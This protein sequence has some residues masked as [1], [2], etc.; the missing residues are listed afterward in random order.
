MF[1][2]YFGP[3]GVKRKIEGK[4]AVTRLG[5]KGGTKRNANQAGGGKRRKPL[6]PGKAQSWLLGGIA[7]LFVSALM[8][9]FVESGEE[10]SAQDYRKQRS[11][12]PIRP[13]PDDPEFG[14]GSKGAVRRDSRDAARRPA[15]ASKY[16]PSPSVRSVPNWATPREPLGA[17]P[18]RNLRRHLC[19][20][21]PTHLF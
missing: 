11:S 21:G 4:K 7:L 18:F 12:R 15:A 8:L 13:L 20:L 9:F 3:D 16:L 14:G 19:Q 1:L 6:L 10:F 17:V 5:A 2:R